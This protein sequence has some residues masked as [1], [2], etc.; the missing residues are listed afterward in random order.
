[1][2]IMSY[3]WSIMKARNNNTDAVLLVFACETILRNTA[4]STMKSQHIY[5]KTQQHFLS[6]SNTAWGGQAE[7][8]AGT[9]RET[10]SADFQLSSKPAALRQGLTV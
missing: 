4:F 2:D 5:L 10:A 1:M 9:D 8:S 3:R 6:S 7:G